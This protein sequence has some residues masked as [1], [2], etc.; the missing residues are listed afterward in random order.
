MAALR[1]RGLGAWPGRLRPVATRPVACTG[2]GGQ[3]D[4]GLVP[5]RPLLQPRA[6]ERFAWTLRTASVPN[7]TQDQACWC[8]WPCFWLLRVASG[9]ASGIPPHGVAVWPSLRHWS[10]AASH[11][12][13]KLRPK[14]RTV[15]AF[16]LRFGWCAFRGEH[17][18]HLT[19]EPVS[20]LAGNRW[21]QQTRK[22]RPPWCRVGK[23]AWGRPCFEG[24][25]RPVC[26]LGLWRPWLAGRQSEGRGHP[27]HA[28]RAACGRPGLGSTKQHPKV[29]GRARG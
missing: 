17:C 15:T 19:T 11:T 24:P 13:G 8:F 29:G 3:G 25:Q 22:R 1:E 21:V 16:R 6:G 18:K 5:C 28:P 2:G 26:A 10:L 4:G 7:D 12:A 9:G 20:R 27:A 23:E 14:M